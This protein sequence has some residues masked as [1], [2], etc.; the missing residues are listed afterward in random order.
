MYV[1][2]ASKAFLAASSAS[3]SSLYIR[4][5]LPPPIARIETRAPVFPSVRSGIAPAPFTDD[6][7]DKAAPDAATPSRN[8]RRLIAIAPPYDSHR[9]N[10]QS[11]LT[12][13]R[14]SSTCLLLALL[15]VPVL[16]QNPRSGD[17][18]EIR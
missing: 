11:M 3:S 17:Q 2:P 16:A 18:T 7:S 15:A 6:A 4:K 13:P 12:V 1:I 5:R 10:N 8:L 14:L 9:S